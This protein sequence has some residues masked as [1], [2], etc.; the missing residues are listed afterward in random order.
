MARGGR[1]VPFVLLGAL[2]LAATAQAGS[3]DIGDIHADYKLT[4]N[5]GVAMRMKEPNNALINGTIDDFRFGRR[6]G[7]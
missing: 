6:R 3:M 2:A 5:Y 4:L 7:Y 1:A